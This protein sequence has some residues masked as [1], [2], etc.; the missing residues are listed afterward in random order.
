M[1]IPMANFDVD[2]HV[3]RLQRDGY[4][5]IEDFLS[6]AELREVRADWQ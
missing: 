1:K 6:A 2:A 3:M 5:I 4:T